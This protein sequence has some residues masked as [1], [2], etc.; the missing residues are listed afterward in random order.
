[1][2]CAPGGFA[3]LVVAAVWW[4]LFVVWIVWVSQSAHQLGLV[5]HV[6]FLAQGVVTPVVDRKEA[7]LIAKTVECFLGR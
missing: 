4:L 1:M 5:L 2:W 6:T 7:A 3:W